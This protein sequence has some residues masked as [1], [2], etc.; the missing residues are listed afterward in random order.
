MDCVFQRE[1]LDA[2]VE[3]TVEAEERIGPDPPNP[4]TPSDPSAPS[5]A[6]SSAAAEGGSILSILK[7]PEEFSWGV[8]FVSWSRWESTGDTISGCWKGLE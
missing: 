7:T 2:E 6:V 5:A 4:S 3:A 1:Y 8:N